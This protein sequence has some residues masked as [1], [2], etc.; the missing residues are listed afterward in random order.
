MSVLEELQKKNPHLPLFSVFDPA[1]APYGQVLPIQDPASLKEAMAQTVIPEKGNQYTASDPILEA[2]PDIRRLADT[3]Y[4][5]MAIQAGCCNGHGFTLNA[6]E[7]HKCSEVNYSTT[8]LVLLLALPSDVH[9]RRLDSAAVVGFYLPPEVLV[10]IRPLVLHFAP[11]RISSEGFNCLVVLTRGTNT[12]LDRV[13]TA[14][15]GEEGLLWMKNKWLLCH[16]DS[17]QAQNG[18]FIGITGEN[19]KLSIE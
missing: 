3:I 12:P 13:D 17:P 14:A 5:G 16:P 7:Y 19:L 1:F 2:V 10:E 8:G 4:G 11:C 18:A 15:P 9:D 6:E